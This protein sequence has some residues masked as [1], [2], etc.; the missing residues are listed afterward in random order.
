VK[1][2]RIIIVAVTLA[3]AVI[4]GC[5][6]NADGTMGNDPA[7]GQLEIC[8]ACENQA[9]GNPR[10]VIPSYPFWNT[11]VIAVDMSLIRKAAAEFCAEKGAEA[12]APEFIMGYLPLWSADRLCGSD[13]GQTAVAALLGNLYI[14]GYFGGLWLRDALGG[15]EE[16]QDMQGTLKGILEDAAADEADFS[17]SRPVFMILTSIARMK[18]NT[19][20]SGNDLATR[21]ADRVSLDPFLMIYGYNWG[22]FMYI[23][24]NPPD[25]MVPPE[26]Y[27]EVCPRFMDCDIPGVT[28]E[29]MR[30]YKPV[31]NSLY[32][33][34]TPRW[35]EVNSLM[36]LWG[37][38][39]VATGENVWGIIM[40][41]STM[42]QPATYE[43]LLDLSGRF[44]MMAELSLLPAMKGYAE[45]DM[46]AGRCGL[47]QEAAMI[48]WAGSYFMGL[49]SDQ[50]DG[51]FPELQQ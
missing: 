30:T 43:L 8:A 48:I 51:T 10:V 31:L 12:N 24:D 19:A 49:G 18:V 46:A 47:L 17:G 25:G 3:F 38:G 37:Q 13:G 36:R 45:G 16:L 11:D 14:S 9:V 35:V 44:M 1:R 15:G 21:I 42:S 6:T 2:Y 34:E 27:D 5:D 40:A 29:T 50:P 23:L 4:S 33:P 41:N 39:A 20:I 22:Y 26:G 7:D 32:A 28:L